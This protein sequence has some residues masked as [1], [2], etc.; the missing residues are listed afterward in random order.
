MLLPTDPGALMRDPALRAMLEAGGVWLWDT[1]L[2]NEV[3]TYQDGFWAQYGYAPDQV[4]ETF[5]FLR[6]VHNADLREIAR[7][8]RAHLDGETETYQAEWRLR[9]AAGEWRWISSRGRVV[10]RDRSGKPLRMVG[11]YTDIT[12]ARLSE[13]G[14]AASRAELDAVFNGSRDGLA[15]I[16]PEMVLL[17][18]NAAG[19]EMIERATGMHPTEGDSIFTIPSLA[20]DRP[21]IGDI[22]LTLAGARP[23]PDRSIS[24]PDG[25]TTL[26]FSYSPVFK[27]DGGI[28]GVA[29]GLRDVTEKLRLEKA[30]LQATRLE[31]MGLL[32]GGI[33]HDFNNL[34]SAI[35]GNIEVAQLSPLDEDTKAGLADARDAARRASELVRDLLVFAGEHRPS[36]LQLNM[37]DLAHEMVRYARKIPGNR[38]ELLEDLAPGL[39]EVAGDATQLRQLILNLVVNALDATRE[40]GSKVHVRTFAV[41]EPR[42]VAVEFVVEPRP[43]PSY[44]VLQVSDDGVGIDETTRARMFDPF[45]T[46]KETGHGIGLASVLGA[47]R[48]HGGSLSVESV[49]GAGATFSVFLPAS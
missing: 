23:R 1:D 19:V 44:V 24:T 28:L 9:T 5:D 10:E 26:E 39:P 17:R 14:L 35:I 34:L 22:E 41:L 36:A 18:I 48:S 6:V 16:S 12:G 4:E 27:E 45:F 46:T 8:W 21:V 42:E 33:A 37:S 47:V 38:A 30:R 7:A 20:A 11:A 25:T 3:T 49:P 31:S 29:V 15:L 2:V 13:I 43:A 40:S 32:A